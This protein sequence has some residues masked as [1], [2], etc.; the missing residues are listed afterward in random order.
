MKRSIIAAIVVAVVVVASLG[1][2]GLN[3]TT[4]PKPVPTEIVIGTSQPLSGGLAEAGGHTLIG[5]L[6]AIDYINEVKGGVYVKEFDKRLPL[7]LV[8]Y[9]DRTE[10]ARA[11]SVAERL[12]KVDGVTA[13]IGPYSSLLTSVM[14]PVAEE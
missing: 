10:T 4:S 9:D 11:K 13:I 2:V 12:I 5:I 1:F 6:A 3:L 14:A 7:R 8:L